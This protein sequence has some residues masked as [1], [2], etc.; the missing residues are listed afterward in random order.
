MYLI[1]SQHSTVDCS[2]IECNFISL[3][4]EVQALFKSMSFGFT[5]SPLHHYYT[6]YVAVLK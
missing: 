6:I 5:Y 1:L 4:V 3:V 2:S